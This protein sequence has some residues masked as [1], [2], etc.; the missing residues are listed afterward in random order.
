MGRTQQLGFGWGRGPHVTAT[1]LE[2]QVW[3]RHLAH[4]G[5][6]GAPT[7]PES[8]RPSA[9]RRMAKARRRWSPR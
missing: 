9:K 7:A 5:D 1:P 3:D 8:V 2:R 4:V 6:A